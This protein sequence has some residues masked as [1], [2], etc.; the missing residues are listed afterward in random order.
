M[1]LL[2]GLVVV[3]RIGLYGL[4]TADIGTAGVCELLGDF[5]GIAV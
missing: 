3:A 1:A 2:D 4:D 5:L